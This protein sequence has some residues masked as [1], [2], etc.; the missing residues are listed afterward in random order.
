MNIRAKCSNSNCSEVGIEKSVVVGQLLGLGA[1]NDRV[2]CSVCGELMKTTETQNTSAKG[3]GNKGRSKGPTY[4]RP[5]RS[6]PTSQKPRPKKRVR[7][8]ISNR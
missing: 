3:R 5:S 7:K 8:R 1:P 4:K 6:R 2:T